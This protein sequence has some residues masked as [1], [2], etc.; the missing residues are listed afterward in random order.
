[1]LQLSKPVVLSAVEVPRMGQDRWITAVPDGDRWLVID[2][3]VWP[4]SSGAITRAEYDGA[5]LRYYD[6]AGKLLREK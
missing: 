3:F 2:D 4:L 1:M 6:G 5:H